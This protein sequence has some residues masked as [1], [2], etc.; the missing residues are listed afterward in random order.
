MTNQLLEI[1][2]NYSGD[3]LTEFFDDAPV[4]MHSVDA[5]GRLI[6]V[7]KFWAK[8]LGFEPD[9]MIGRRATD[10]M[11]ESSRDRAINVTLPEFRRAGKADNISYDFLHRTGA[12]VPVIMSAIVQR[13]P[14]G[15]YCHSLVVISEA[16]ISSTKVRAGFHASEALSDTG[17]TLSPLDRLAILPQ[18][19]KVLVAEDNEMNRKVLQAYMHPASI[20]AT[21][22]SNGRE[23]LDLLSAETFDAAIIDIDMPV[24]NG[25]DAVR[26]Y[27]LREVGSMSP[28]LPIIACTAL[29]GTDSI[30]QFMH[31]GFDHYLPKPIS[32]F[33]FADCFDWVATYVKHQMAAANIDDIT[34]LPPQ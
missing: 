16:P 6:Q 30:N 19:L 26:Q 2:K 15:S 27:R 18:S 5:D 32:V 28:R 20:E 3:S 23:A 4:M 29:D 22:V 1:W 34:R 25:L 24:M 21:Y 12:I 9:E 10:F 17:S 33:S 8:R 14:D 7:N 31:A 13:K 11:T